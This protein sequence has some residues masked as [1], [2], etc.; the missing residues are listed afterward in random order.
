MAFNPDPVKPKKLA[1]WVVSSNSIRS[2]VPWGP[3]G[4][5]LLA[6]HQY[7]AVGM[8][9]NR[10][11]DAAHQRSPDPT[12]APAAHYYQPCPYLLGQRDDR[13]G[14]PSLYQML[15]SYR[16]P[17]RAYLLYLSLK[18]LSSS[19]LGD[20]LTFLSLRFVVYT[21]EVGGFGI[22]GRSY[23]DDAEGV[24]DVQL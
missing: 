7:G 24:N 1:S 19:L 9:H 6:Y 17:G 20:P 21:L 23:R 11:R 3:S 13:R 18:H 8:P 15:L 4:A 14:Y 22:D 16:A 2:K 10:V 5:A 12:Q